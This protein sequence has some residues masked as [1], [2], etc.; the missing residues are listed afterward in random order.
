[1]IV[2]HEDLSTQPASEPVEFN[3]PQSMSDDATKDNSKDD[4]GDDGD[5]SQIESTSSTS[6]TPQTQKILHAMSACRRRKGKKRR[7]NKRNVFTPSPKKRKR[8]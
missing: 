5:A 1:L 8:K 3:Q 6:V 7:I 2:E 4:D